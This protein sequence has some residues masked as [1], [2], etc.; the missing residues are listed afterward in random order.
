MAVQIQFRRGTAAEWAQSNPILAEAEMGIEID[1]SLFKIGDGIR[2]WNQLDYGGVKGE[3]G[4]TGYVGSYG[5]MAVSNVLYVS[6]S[7]NDENDGQSLGTS[8]LTIKAALAI[9]GPNTTIFVKSG[10]YI[11]Q[12][13]LYVPREVA[14]VGDNLRTVTVRP[15]NLAEDLF[16]VNNA[17]Y[18]AHM[19]FR[20]HVSPAAAVAFPAD[21]SAGVIT[22]SPY[23]QNCTSI[24]STGTGMRIDGDLALGT[25][26]MVV[27]AYTQY[28]QGGIGIH[29][30][31]RG[32]AQL[33]SVFTICCDKGFFAESGGFCSI[34]NSNS[35]FG[36]Y[37]LYA[38]GVSTPIQYA[39]IT[40]AT[41]KTITFS[42]LVQ[43]PSIGDAIT[44]ANT[45]TYYTVNTSSALTIGTIP[46]VNPT[47]SNESADLRNARQAILNKKSRI[48]V[49]TINFLNQTYPT[50]Q[51]NQF[52][53]NRDIATILNCVAY[54]VVLGS[55]YQSIN[56]G[57][58]YT[59]AA[60]AVVK[61]LQKMETIAAIEFVKTSALAAL[62]VGTLAY[63]RASANFDIILSILAN[64]VSAAPTITYPNPSVISTSTVNAKNQIQANKEFIKAETLKYIE[65]NYITFSYN[66]VKCSR[67][68]SLIIDGLITDLLFPDNGYTQSNFAGLQYWNQ[69]SYITGI[70]GELTT[71]TNAIN[72]AS[73]LAQK[74]V[75]NITTG[76]RYQSTVTQIS[77]LPE[78]STSQTAIIAADFSVITDILN[79]G[80]V[81]I[82]DRIVSPSASIVSEDAEFAYNLLQAN[83][84]Y[85]QAEAVAYVESTKTVGFV[86][87]QALCYRDIGYIVDCISFDTLYGG[88]RQAVQAGVYY[89]G[90]N[91]TSTAIPNEIPQTTAAYNRLKIILPDIVNNKSIKR[92]IGNNYTQITNIEPASVTES[93]ALQTMVEK[94]KTIINNGPSAADARRPINLNRTLSQTAENAASIIQANKAFLTAEIIGYI[95]STFRGFVYD[96]AKCYRDTGLIV[97]AIAQD[98]LFQGVSQSTFAGIQYWSQSSTTENIIPG[99]LTTTTFAIKY[100]SDLAQKVVQ[101]VTSG[102]RYQSIITQ[103]TGTTTAIVNTATAKLIGNDFEVITDIL[104][105]GTEGVTDIIIPN[106]I[107]AST[108]SK[109]VAAYNLLQANKAYLQAEA[110]GWIEKNS[111]TFQYDQAKCAR[112]TGLIVDSFITDL[113][114]P[115]NGY[116]QSNFSG[117]QYWNQ[118][119]YTGGIA[120][121]LTTTTNAIKYVSGLAQK[122]V[123]GNTSGTRYSTATQ[124][125]NLP[126]AT[127]VEAT[128]IANDFTII[129]DILTKGTEG[130]TDLIVSPSPAPLS[131]NRQRAFNLLQ[132]N[133]A[134]LQAEAIAY[135]EA[136]K[137]SGFTYDSELCAR[138]VGF[139]VD[140]V[141]FDVLYGGNRQAVQSGVCYYGFSNSSS[142][143]PN[144][145]TQTVAAYTRL[146]AILPSIITNQSV[147]RSVGNTLTQTTDLPAATASEGTSLDQMVDLITTII[148][149]G[150]ELANALLPVSITKTTNQNI[151]NA[152]ALLSANREFIKAEIIAYIDQTYRTGFNYD[153]FKCTRDTGLIVDS[154]AFDILYEGNSQSTFAGIQYR[155][156][157]GYT[158]DILRELTTTTNAILHVKNFMVEFARLS[159]GTTASNIVRNNFDAIVEIINTNTVGGIAVTDA[160]VPNGS[161]STNTNIIAAYN[162]LLDNKAVVQSTTIAWINS[163]NPG[164]AYNTATCYR[165]VGYIIDSVAFD[166]LHGGNRQSVMS[167][168][169][170]YA[171]STSTT[172]IAN[173]T[174]QTVA[175]YNFIKSI[176]ASIV[177]G[178]AVT[179]TYQNSVSQTIT[180]NTATQAEVLI[181]NTNTD[182]IVNIINNGPAVA[183]ARTPINL[184]ASTS[185][186]KFNAYTLLLQNRKFIQAETIAYI[187]YTF[188]SFQYSRNKCYRDVGYMIDSVSIDLLYGGNKQAVQSGVAYFGYIST[189]SVVATELTQTVRAYNYINSLTQSIILGRAVPQIFQTEVEQVTNLSTAT[190]AQSA[191]IASLITTMTNIITNGPN[192][193]PP[194][195]SIGVIA[196]TNTNVV[197]A[198]KLL[199]ANREFIQAEVIAYANYTFTNLDPLICGRDIGYVLDALSYDI[200]YGGNSQTSVAGAA[201][202]N[203]TTNTVAF[204]LEQMLGAYAFMNSLTQQ[205]VVGNSVTPLQNV[206]VRSTNT[207]YA[208]A[209]EGTIVDTLF[210]IINDILSN[211]YSCVITI[212]ESLKVFPSKGESATT[213]QYSLIV[214]TGHS[215]EWIGAGTDINAALPYLGGEPIA[216]NQ[217]FEVNGGKVNFTGTDQ[218]GDF[219][220]GNDL[221]INRNNGTI[222]GRT[223][224]KSL[225]AV[226]TP[227]ILS[228][229]G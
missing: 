7:G 168:V 70:A 209:S 19:T 185:T 163:N 111:S 17:C 131:T 87:D 223:F 137:T 38:D 191:T 160:I 152:G 187:D 136:R 211:G 123:V 18:L 216:E 181:I 6:K 215:F 60:S 48:Q 41:R 2:T 69:A 125:T 158:G 23:V 200:M 193:A 79:T 180:A 45:T 44:W 153:R 93:I 196:S 104:N 14:I 219:R 80:T 52:K 218:R 164:F 214:S 119:G 81:G 117:L 1:T 201:Y 224:T 202:Y 210:D 27:D 228:I 183:P 100:V 9:S 176:S 53:C 90:Y 82:T 189:S 65:D 74:I 30:L 145:S 179:A 55:N 91:S 34:T 190:T 107:T 184:N 103:V 64:G 135:V 49:D 133:K 63:T 198:A 203:G 114:F 169:Y 28:N 142:A 213:H 212:E 99:E 192:V 129:T 116:T 37:A 51:F 173:E 141:G 130:V 94:I 167:G 11:E 171:A 225:F 206:V 204:V 78:A 229:G 115:G 50:F 88:N 138:D 112:D 221:V 139:M 127:S 108:S 102:P 159:G 220:I 42:N 46:V 31:N 162:S 77:N 57:V 143:I 89:Y 97:D 128:A 15:A 25:K 174:T 109:I 170:Y 75:R 165:D 47:I 207:N 194:L 147:T 72:Y 186:S 172:V 29:L 61:Q 73:S 132:A 8:K 86:Y 21:G 96:E 71:T 58:A 24:T 32:Y 175:A 92:S 124:V 105:N 39:T 22:T 208:S 43:R 26:S 16:Y 4:E 101:G 36:N 66:K 10:D 166:L 182:L 67:D 120:G 35:S 156:Q 144:E 150:P 126:L 222:S 195:T 95:D 121:E 122:I 85:I 84:T 154:L 197:N 177:Q 5:N 205:I 62:T 83:R 40:T 118:A 13:P 155:T 188:N 199:H 76:T 68:T 12:N 146:K 20:D 56:A 110:I 217:G 151:L 33:V 178:I 134:Y 59:R 161:A 54:D 98:L 226:M 106:G 157:V 227:Y 113:L 149:G 3:K 148:S 140:S